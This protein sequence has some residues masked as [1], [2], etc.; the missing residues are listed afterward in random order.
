MAFYDI[1]VSTE[2]NIKKVVRGTENWS[3]SGTTKVTLGFRPSYV[4]YYVIKN[5]GAVSE[6]IIW[7]SKYPNV[8]RRSYANTMENAMPSTDAY[9]IASIDSDGFTVNK[10]N[11]VGYA[12]TLEYIVIR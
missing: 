5:T 6:T 12:N 1:G 2:G 3:T 7:D 8:Q 11:G 10:S 9:C 4:M